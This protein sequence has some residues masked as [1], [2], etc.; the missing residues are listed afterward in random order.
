LDIL[1]RSVKKEESSH[2]AS[3]FVRDKNGNTKESFEIV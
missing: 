1:A 3:P 2:C